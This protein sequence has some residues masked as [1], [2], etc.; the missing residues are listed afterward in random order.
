MTTIR[1]YQD[2]LYG[3][4]IPAHNWVPAP[5]FLL[6][7]SRILKHLPV[8]QGD[9]RLLE[10]GCG[11]GALVCDFRSLG[12]SCYAVE[13][14]KE[15]LTIALDVHDFDP[16]VRISSSLPEPKNGLFDVLVSCEV[17]EHIEDDYTALKSWSQLL[18]PGG[19][20]ILSAP[21]DPKRFGANDIS[22]GHFR[23][24]TV[25]GF[26]EL[27]RAAELEPVHFESYGYPFVRITEI[28]REKLKASNPTVEGDEKRLK[29][30]TQSGV[31]RIQEKKIFSFL[32][33]G[34][35]RI[36]FRTMDLFQR[37][38]LKFEIGNGML[39]LARRK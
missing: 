3:L 8:A 33:T 29:A 18:K 30:T 11:A 4:V 10:V 31:E 26:S 14:S 13:I 6:R 39:C 38:F 2:P 28:A 5:R 25:A 7:R 9:Q 1:Y 37:I 35:G 23:R 16:G 27:C 15:A 22:V 20:A 12:Y 34:I 19:L 21:S 32:D 24:Y 17:L 36:S